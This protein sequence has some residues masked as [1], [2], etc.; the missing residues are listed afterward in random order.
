VPNDRSKLLGAILSSTFLGNDSLSYVEPKCSTAD[1]DWPIYGSLGICSEVKNITTLARN[2]PVITNLTTAKIA[3]L[4]NSSKES[5]ALFAI[6]ERYLPTSVLV[7]GFVFSPTG[8]F[9]QS[10]ADTMSADLFIA[11]S[12]K[13]LNISEGFDD[14]SNFQFLEMA[15][16]WCVK[17]YSTTVKNGTATTI[18]LSRRSEIMS[19]KPG[20]ASTS[21]NTFGNIG[22]RSCYKTNPPRCRGYGGTDVVFAPPEGLPPTSPT[23]FWMD[24]WTALA[25]S[26]TIHFNIGGGLLQTED[27]TIYAHEGDTSLALSTALFGDRMGLE[28]HPPD[29]QLENIRRTAENIARGISNALRILPSIVDEQSSWNG[30]A[31][32]PQ[33][34]F[35]VRWPW[36]FLISGQLMLTWILFFYMIWLNNR[37]DL[38]PLRDDFFATGHIFQISNILPRI[39]DT[40]GGLRQV[41]GDIP[42][43]LQRDTGT[44]VLRLVASSLGGG[45]SFELSDLERVE[46]VIL[47]A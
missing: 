36:L 35:T 5:V 45:N 22:F 42:V 21:L 41:A 6:P 27:L 25:V 18:E 31:Y 19:P 46:N 11:Y 34:V 37:W 17:S 12:N 1:C 13:A 32:F 9:N 33:V 40:I 44:R 43:L 10:V 38:E 39:F 30:T 7:N 24:L 8:V 15:F 4:Y 14:L 3:S 26:Y 28:P 20:N 23:R 47:R 2:D 16:Y 29:I